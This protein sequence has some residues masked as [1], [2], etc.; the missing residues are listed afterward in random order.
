[1]QGSIVHHHVSSGHCKPYLSKPYLVT[2][3]AI[4]SH[5]INSETIWIY[6]ANDTNIGSHGLH[7]MM[8]TSIV[9]CSQF[10]PFFCWHCRHRQRLQQHHTRTLEMS[11]KYHQSNCIVVMLIA[12]SYCYSF[13]PPRRVFIYC[14]QSYFCVYVF[15]YDLVAKGAAQHVQ[16]QAY[17]LQA[18][19]VGLDIVTYIKKYFRYFHIY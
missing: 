8:R 2:H 19:P 16:D 13:D 7:S 5:C 1:M 18:Y 17:Y 15:K 6:S 4:K 11:P 9:P 3:W 14:S 12:L 10:H